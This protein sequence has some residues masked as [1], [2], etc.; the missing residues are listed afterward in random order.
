[1]L[2]LAISMLTFG[3]SYGQSEAIEIEQGVRRNLVFCEDS[4]V[5][6]D[7]LVQLIGDSVYDGLKISI[8]NF[9]AGKER[10]ECPDHSSSIQLSWLNENGTLQLSGAASTAEY[11]A[12][13]ANTIYI[14][15]NAVPDTASRQIAVTL[16]DADFL[17][18]TG[19]FYQYYSQYNITW[20][21]ARDSAAAKNY[22]GLQG[23]LATIT[24]AAE[25]DFI[26]TK[27]DGVGWIGATDS[28]EYSEE[29][30]WVWATGPEAETVFWKG[31]SGGSPVNGEYSFWGGGEPNNSYTNLN[32]GIGED[33]A[34][35]TQDPTQPAKSWN[36]LRNAGD[37]DFTYTPNYYI[38]RGYVVEYGGMDGDPE[39]SLSASF[40]ILIRKPI[41][42]TVADHTICQH[43]SV[44]LNHVYAGNYQWV[45]AAGLSSPD[46]SKPKASPADT[47]T[48]M[49]VA[50]WEGCIDSAYFTVNVKPVPDFDLGED[51]NLCMGDSVWLDAT[52]LNTDGMETYSWNTGAAGNKI[53]LGSNGRYSVRVTN[54]FQCLSTDTVDVTIHEY[55]QITISDKA[56]LTCDARQLTIDGSVDKGAIR[57]TGSP[58]LTFD[59]ETVASPLIQAADTGYFQASVQVTDDFGCISRDTVE[60]SFYDRPTTD[61]N[62]DSIS[63]SGYSLDVDY[64][65]NASSNAL[66]SWYFPDTLYAEGRNLRELNIA[67][68]FQ[69]TNQR[70][71]GLQI[72]ESG[73]ITEQDWTPIR[74]TPNLELT[75]DVTE[76][77]MPL[78]TQFQASSTETIESYSWT[79][80][81]GAEEQSAT[82]VIK[83][84]YAAAGSFDVGLTVVSADGCTNSGLAHDF[85]T[86]FPIRSAETDVDPNRCYPH[87]FDVLYT[88]SGT[89]AD[90]YHW[91]L[92]ELDP[93]E[94]LLDPET[95]SGPLSIRLTDKPTATIGLW[96]ESDKGCQSEMKTFK[97]KRKPWFDIEADVVSGCSPLTVNLSAKQLDTIDQ[98]AYR[99]STG[100]RDDAEGAGITEQ[101]IEQ[102]QEYRVW[103]V[104]TSAL[105][106]CVDTVAFA[107]PVEIY[108]DPVAQF[109]PDRSE[110]LISD[111]LFQ[112]TNNSSG[113]ESYDWDFGDG[114]LSTDT[115]PDYRYRQVGWFRVHLLAESEFG[116]VDTTS[117]RV[118]VAPEDLFPPNALN[119]NSSNPENR[120]FRLAAD[121]VQEQGYQMQIFNRWGEPMFESTDKAVGWDGRM[122]NG[123]FAPPGVYVWILNFNDVMDKP[124]RQKGT[125][126]LVF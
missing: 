71:L 66:F 111:A 8:A 35:I 1:M 45:P 112:F 44:A 12:A 77:C 32:G 62:I 42:S 9:S 28:D 125:V 54:R 46:I 103:A 52:P 84:T 74:V 60:L 116:C 88:G 39:L 75:A 34:H 64:V 76:G 102:G 21:A 37:S 89:V 10:L 16:L 96:V 41:F 2:L 92:S 50:N 80:G 61:L 126:T 19:H 17:P 72:N 70:K 85:I 115:N 95:T 79:F 43:D 98:L 26:W 81:D 67:L 78:E 93:D 56:I 122:K 11:E 73:C 69:Q 63:C 82:D 13:I 23:Y 7:G 114:G 3:F 83:H 5:F 99:W 106:G 104:A 20:T 94:I 108:R 15:R 120:I 38:P 113:A 100:L 68:G 24:S 55:P 14:N 4:I 110:R 33:Y 59:D 124:H 101:Y 118:L 107:Q 86:V 25:N 47:T 90:T 36:D 27:I 31:T 48:Y 22:R 49:V 29:G 30:E 119:P 97:V 6:G 51:R 117:R 123:R 65:G 121:A 53:Q 105:T 57:W 40:E 18:E 109:E 58:A 91:D 87:Q